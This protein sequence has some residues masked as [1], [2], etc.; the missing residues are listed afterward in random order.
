MTNKEK[1]I[2]HRL[3]LDFLE[4]IIQVF[5]TSQGLNKAQVTQKVFP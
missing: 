3:A 2:P 4:P 1:N 5:N